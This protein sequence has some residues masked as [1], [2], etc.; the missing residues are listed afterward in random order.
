[1]ELSN[2]SLIMTFALAVATIWL[3]VNRFSLPIDS[4]WP[5]AYYAML[6]IHAGTIPGLLNPYV[7]YLAVVSG[8]L[9]RF[10]FM[11]RRLV[12]LVRS[13]ELACFVMIGWRL[14]ASLKAEFS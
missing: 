2:I 6:V 8:L 13:L 4:N 12:R 9:L 11:N 5:L 3:G 7:L 1:M 14:F 10:E